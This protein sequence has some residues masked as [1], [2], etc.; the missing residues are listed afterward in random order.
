MVFSFECEL[1]KT[2]ADCFLRR[3]MR[4]FSS[5]LGLGEIERAAEIGVRLLGWSDERAKW[6]VANYKSEVEKLTGFA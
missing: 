3:T 1:A 5:D 4:G 6:E 2:V